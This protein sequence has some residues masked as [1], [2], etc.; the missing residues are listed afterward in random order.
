[1]TKLVESR[2]R[3]DEEAGQEEKG[4]QGRR[5]ELGGPTCLHKRPF[6]L[7]C[8]IP[9]LWFSRLLLTDLRAGIHTVGA[10]HLRRDACGPPLFASGIRI[11]PRSCPNLVPGCVGWKLDRERRLETFYS[12]PTCVGGLYRIERDGLNGWPKGEVYDGWLN[13]FVTEFEPEFA[14]YAYLSSLGGRRM[15]RDEVRN[16]NLARFKMANAGYKLYTPPLGL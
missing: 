7:V 1:M 15:R 13:E 14:S 9:F 12:L 8:T 6:L 5:W 16:R 10:L 3:G 11:Q 2:K 4:R